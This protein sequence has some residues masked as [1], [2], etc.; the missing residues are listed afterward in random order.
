MKLIS[1]LARKFG[2]FAAMDEYGTDIRCF[3]EA[4]A[5]AWLPSLAP[6]AVIYNHRTGAVVAVR[7]QGAR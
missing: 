4:G 7:H 3:T 1:K 6:K 5:R 2:N